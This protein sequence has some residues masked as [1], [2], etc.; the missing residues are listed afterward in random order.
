MFRSVGLT[1]ESVVYRKQLGVRQ[2][3]S[4]VFLLKLVKPFGIATVP[5]APDVLVAFVDEL[6]NLLGDLGSNVLKVV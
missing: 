2:L 3:V 6:V 5:V 1:V 4:A